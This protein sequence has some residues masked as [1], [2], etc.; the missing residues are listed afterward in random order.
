MCL[1]IIILMLLLQKLDAP[2]AYLLS[3]VG[4]IYMCVVRIWVTAR[5]KAGAGIRSPPVDGINWVTRR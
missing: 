3:A 5:T 4:Y 1:R 2:H